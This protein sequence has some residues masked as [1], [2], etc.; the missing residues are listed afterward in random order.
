[1]EGRA[2]VQVR[3]SRIPYMSLVIV[4][5]WTLGYVGHSV[6]HSLDLAFWIL[7]FSHNFIQALW[8]DTA[9][10]FFPLLAWKC[11]YLA[12][13]SPWSLGGSQGHPYTQGHL[14]HLASY[15]WTLQSG[16]ATYQDLE[17]FCYFVVPTR[18]WLLKTAFPV[19]ELLREF[20]LTSFVLT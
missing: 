14:Q 12:L 15:S 8:Q 5:V 16:K 9:L 2:L 6:I 18:R 13:S 17:D 1:M 4:V 20:L 7:L 3:D 10:S 11:M 19:Y